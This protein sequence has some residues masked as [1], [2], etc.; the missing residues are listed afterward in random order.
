[1][2]HVTKILFVL[3]LL[4]LV[5][6]PVGILNAADTTVKDTA[7]KQEKTEKACCPGCK[8]EMDKD[9]AKFKVEY[10][11]KTYYFCSEECKAAFEKDPEK[12]AACGEGDACCEAKVSYVCP[13]KQCNVKTD[14]PGK[15][16]KCGME[17]KKVVEEGAC[18]KKDMEKH[19]HQHQHHHQH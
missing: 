9:A 10:K 18:C 19:Q 7:V 14:K 11:G 4:S 15:C 8:N 3:I 16:P 6:T 17:L 12:Y 13:M 2:K 5:I 1:M